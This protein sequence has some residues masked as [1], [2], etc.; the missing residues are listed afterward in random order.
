MSS[1]SAPR[2][3]FLCFKD[4]YETGDGSSSFFT[5]AY[6]FMTT[7]P[8][9]ISFYFLEDFYMNSLELCL[10]SAW[11]SLTVHSPLLESGA[12]SFMVLDFSCPQE[13]HW[14]GLQ[15]GLSFSFQPSLR[16]RAQGQ[17]LPQCGRC[18]TM[19]LHGLS[20]HP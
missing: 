1:T 10:Q 15:R 8:T 14:Q 20:G 5:T 6:C 9:P 4:T 17:C 7:V 12:W 11:Y 16:L 13:L 2:A 3:L 19:T 18:R